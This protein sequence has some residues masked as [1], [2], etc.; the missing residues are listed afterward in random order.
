MMT[1]RQLAAEPPTIPTRTSW[2]LTDLAEARG[3]Q[4]LFTRQSPQKLKVLREHALIE[5]AVSSNRI[6]GVEV[7]QSRVGTLIFGKPALRDRDE[8]EVRGY[9]DA[10]KLIHEI[11]AKLSVSQAA[12]K[13]LHKLCRGDIWDAGQY[14]AKDVD[15]IQTYADGR[16]RVRFKTVPAKQTPKFMAETMELWER[17][18]VEKWVHPL[19]LLAALN[20][21][22]LCVHPFRDGNGRVSRLLLLQSLYHCG[23][24]VGRYISLERLIE[25]HKERYYETL[26]QSSARWHEGKHDPWPYLNYLLFI[27]TQACKEFERRVGEVKSPRGEKTALVE[28][29]IRRHTG[30]FRIAD[31]QRGQHGTRHGTVLNLRPNQRVPRVALCCTH[32]TECDVVRAHYCPRRCWDACCARYY[33]RCSI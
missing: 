12:I 26:E 30:S 33:T 9:R 16:S 7:D 22:F 21:D 31:L 11:G 27:L 20:L 14:K 23:F 2:Y 3:K 18:L 4:E 19:V 25:E 8:E 32:S 24:E 10:L 5:S 17:G 28:T 13:R 1:L 6:E 15:I 29:A